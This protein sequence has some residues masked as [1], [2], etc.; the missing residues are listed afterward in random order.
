MSWVITTLTSSI[1]KKLLTALTGLFLCTFLVVHL[2]GN[3]QLLYSDEGLA[4]NTYARFM[5]TNPVIKVTSYI[6]YSSILFH[7][8]LG[9]YLVYK[10]K[11]ARPVGYGAV[12]NQSV[13]ASR[14]MG[15]LGTMILV[16]IVV[17]MAD[18]WREYHYS[19]LAY[20]KYTIDAMAGTTITEVLT[21]VKK[22]THFDY[23][24]ENGVRTVI[25][26][27]LYAECQEAFEEWWYVLLYVLS[28]AA[29][30][31]HLSHGF[32]SGFQTLGL[33][34]KKY[35]GGIKTFGFVFAIVIPAAFAFIP[36]YMFLCK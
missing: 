27:D 24:I 5:T 4:F 9:L 23:T 31:F 21:G 7:A 28:M 29:L 22:G 25:A 17:H 20:K 36:V 6:L 33:N 34:H 16:F 15:I 14:N 11:K 19:D 18:F 3:L 2:I 10:N 1:G 26:K 30:A 32:Q 8:F 12:D 13:W 35:T